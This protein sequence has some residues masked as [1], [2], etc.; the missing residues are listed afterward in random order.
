MNAYAPITNPQVAAIDL[1]EPGS[2][3]RPGRRGFDM[4]GI[5]FST[6]SLETYAFSDRYPVVYD[7][8]TVAAAVEFSDCSVKRP[9]NDWYR[10]FD[11]RIP[12]REPALWQAK[13]TNEALCSALS[14]LTGDF[15]SIEFTQMQYIPDIPQPDQFDFKPEPQFVIPYSD[16]MDS[17]AVAGILAH[18]N[19]SVCQPLKIMLGAKTQ[20]DQGITKPAPFTGMPYKLSYPDRKRE[21]SARNRGF[22]FFLISGIAA[23]LAKVDEIAIPESG[24]GALGPALLVVGHIYPDYRN[25]PIFAEKM[26]HLF[27]ELFDRDIKIRFPRLWHTKGET[28]WDYVFLHGGSDWIKTRSCWRD[29]RWVSVKGNRRQCG[30]CAACMLRRLSVHAAGL[31]EPP[32]TYVAADLTKPSLTEAAD[33]SYPHPKSKAFVEYAIAGFLHL[34]HMA[35]LA[36]DE[37]AEKVRVHASLLGPTL[38][39]SDYEAETGIFDLL[40]RHKKEWEDY[41]HSLGPRSFLTENRSSAR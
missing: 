12:L 34:D 23:F 25:H 31:H 19:D 15:W 24:Q 26:E 9:V 13:E 10:H 40:S 2:D 41:M 11:L 20:R 18:D 30:V 38:G 16:G 1:V 6:E 39:I 33:P 37:H 28:L 3:P 27:K 36:N 17:K 32:D 29:S 35:E 5:R 4:S 14:F 22:K 7:A 8:L 21:L